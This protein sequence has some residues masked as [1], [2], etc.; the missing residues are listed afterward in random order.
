M[1]KQEYEYN[2]TEIAV[3][4]MSGRFPGAR[5]INEFWENLRNGIESISSFSEQELLEQGNDPQL[6]QKPNY[7]RAKGFVED[8]Q[9]FDATFFDYTP[10]EAT[11]MDPQ[12]R[13]LHE[14][15]WEA[16]EDA[17]YS[18]GA[19]EK[20]IGLFAG[21]AFNHSWM[22]RAFARQTMDNSEILETSMYTL[23]DYLC[24]LV[25]YKLDLKGPSF[26]I[27]TACSTSLVAIHQASQSLLLGECRLAVAGGV[28]ITLPSKTGYLY[29][30]GMINSPDGH[31]RTFDEQA[32]GTVFG[33]GAGIVVLKRLQEAIDAGDHIY[34]VIRGSAIN[35]D[36]NQKVGYTAPS[37]KGQEAVIRAALNVAEVDPESIS[38][39]EAHGTGTALG[40]PIE[41]EALKAAFRT[42]QRGYC[43]I[44]SVKSNI[45]HLNAA[46][47]VAGFLK[48]V[49]ALQHRQIPP[50]L[51]FERANP[52]IDFATSP[53]V[54]STQL[55][56]WHNEHY[57]LRAGVSSFGIGGTNA[58]VILEEAP[59]APVSCSQRDWHVLPLSAKSE[60][61]LTQMAQRLAQAL[62]A[63]PDIAL[64]DVAYTLQ[65]GR[66]HFGH[67]RMVVAHSV[68]QA[69]AQLGQ[70]EVDPGN[71]G[72]VPQE[73][74]PL[75]WLFPGQGT[76]YVN[77]GQHLYARDAV[78]RAAIE[79]CLDLAQAYGA[80]DLRALLYP[81]AVDAESEQ[82]LQET[83]VAQPLLFSVEYAL[84]QV[85]LQW[86]IKP[87][88][89][90]GHSIGEYVAAC[91]AGVFSLEDAMRL[92]VKRGQLMSQAPTGAMLSV[93][94]SEEH[95]Q[96]YLR[97]GLSLA[98]VNTPQMCVVAG[99]VELI[100]VLEAEMQRDGHR[101]R[102]V[103]TSHAFHSA[104]ME[105]VLEA[106]GEEAK[107]VT[108][109]A[110]Q[111][112]Y[113]SNVSGTWIQE[114]EATDPA[115]WVRHLRVHVRFAEGISQMLGASTAM[116]VEVGPGNSLSTFARQGQ[117]ASKEQLVL[118]LLRHRREEQP[119]DAYLLNRLGRLWVAG[120]NLNWT[121]AYAEEQRR[122]LSLPT[123]PF[124]RQRFWLELSG[125]QWSV[126]PHN[127]VATT[128]EHRTAK[129]EAL[130]KQHLQS[131]EIQSPVEADVDG[132]EHVIAQI[133]EQ[134]LGVKPEL[135]DSFFDIGG[136]S[137][138]ATSLT[139]RIQ[140][141]CHVAV[142]I[143]DIFQFA[144]VKALSD[145]IRQLEKTEYAEIVPVGKKEYYA[146]SSSQRRTYIIQRNIGTG[147]TYNYPM[148]MFV[149][150][151]P[152]NKRIEAAFRSLINRHEIFR[153]TFEF[154]DGEP[155]QK[156]HEQID[157]SIEYAHIQE[158][159]L[160][161][162]IKA[163]IQPFDL[164]HVPLLRVMSVQLADQ[165]YALFLD[166][167]NIL[168]DG[169][170]MNIFIKEFCELYRGAIL[171]PL[172][173]QYKDYAEWQQRFLT[174]ALIRKQ[175]AYW[176]NKFATIPTL[177]MP[178]DASRQQTQEFSGETI[179]FTVSS[180]LAEMLHQFARERN[181]TLNVLFYSAFTLLLHKYSGQVDLVVG[182]LV[183]GRRRTEVAN[184][185]GLFTNFLPVRN[186]IVPHSS[187]VQYLEMVNLLLL[188]AYD[189]Q[190]Y[191]FDLIVEKLS[192]RIPRS[193]NPL[194]DAMFVYHNEYDPNITLDVE[195]LQFER[196]DFIK[197][198]AKLDIKLDIIDRRD[199]EHRCVLQYNNQLYVRQ[200]IDDF[201]AHFL[202]LLHLIIEQ[203]ESMLSQFEI[204][205]F[206]EEQAIQAKRALLEQDVS[207]ATAMTLVVCATFT[208]TP[209]ENYIK[210][211]GRTFEQPIAVQFSAYN[212]IFQDLLDPSSLLSLNNGA[213]LLLIRFED[214]LRDTTSDEQTQ[215]R[216][217]EQNFADL[218]RVIQEKPKSIPYFVGLFAL[219][220]EQNLS[221]TLQTYITMLNMRWK[222]AMSALEN[223]YVIDFSNLSDLYLVEK[224]F[225]P[226]TDRTAHL[227]FTDGFYAAMGTEIARKIIAW[228]QHPFKVI[229]LDADN[230][231]WQGVI[232][233][234]GPDGIR[235]DTPYIELQKFMQKKRQEGFLLALCSKNNDVDVWEV[236]SSNAQMLLKKDDFV[237][238]RVNWQPKSQNIK[239][240]AVELRVGLDSFIFIDDSAIECMEVMANCPEVLTLQLPQSAQQIP[241]FLNHLWGLDKLNVTA[242]DQQR[243]AMY[244]AEQRR[245]ETYGAA[246]TH[247]DFL[248]GL[249]LKMSMQV[250]EKKQS[251]RTAQMT[252]RTNQFNVS[253]IRRSEQQIQ[254]L[255]MQT[256]M[257]C[258]FVEV[259]DR[260]GYYG[261]TG[262]V[263]AKQV[264]DTLFIDTF[265]LS[266]RVLGRNIEDAVVDA[267]L[268]Y[269]LE[270]GINQ[271]ATYYYATS[272]NQIVKEFLERTNWLP[273]VEAEDYISYTLDVQKAATKQAHQVD[274]YYNTPLPHRQDAIAVSIES[275]PIQTEMHK[276][277]NV[278][279]TSRSTP[280]LQ[281]H[282]ALVNDQNS[283][284]RAYYA[285]IEHSS[286]VLLLQL[287]VSTVA[288]VDR[289]QLY[290]APRNALEM[291]LCQLWSSVL[292]G[293]EVGI[294]DSFFA[295]GGNSLRAIKLEVELEK[296][297]LI[298][299]G[300][301][302]FINP[303][304]RQYAEKIAGIH[305]QPSVFTAAAD[306]EPAQASANHAFIC[307]IKPFNDFIYK[308]CFYSSVFPI[309]LS[310]KRSIISFIINDSIVYHYDE[311]QPGTGLTIMFQEAVPISS[312]LQSQG[313]V[314]VTQEHVTNIIDTI[315][316]A[317]EQK[318][319][320]VLWVDCFY[321]SIRTD[322]YHRIHH[323]HT[324]LFYGYERDEQTFNIIEHQNLESPVYE[325]R[326]I[327]FQDVENAYEGFIQHFHA[328]QH[329]TYFQFTA[330]PDWVDSASNNLLETFKHNNRVQKALFLDG[331]QALQHF[332]DDYEHMIDDQASLQEYASKL[333]LALSDIINA[334]KVAVYTLEHLSIEQEVIDLLKKIVEGW[335]A[336]R[337]T[338]A[339]FQYSGSYRPKALRASIVHLDKIIECE[340]LYNEW[341][342]K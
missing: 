52:R 37:T 152:D 67:R 138:K 310:L 295:I 183:A 88:G 224:I 145:H 151:T 194:F 15:V 163:F 334:K 215:V 317:L 63:K 195:G 247:A 13:L 99:R 191:P 166:M 141:E 186:L 322:V 291:K 111:I 42:Q 293:V 305:M 26:T 279:P 302:I 196:Y 223:V 34:A 125:L 244:V 157:F 217:L 341:L 25:S 337:I 129:Q 193:R 164:E 180:E 100:E 258:W 27:Q 176:L 182:S 1:S 264:D 336:I 255:L 213:N 140:K 267:L 265:L 190:D 207:E 40:D 273:G 228:K 233:E 70:Q 36:G 29:Q 188:E 300:E 58:H 175:E 205:T 178:L 241:T 225:D 248:Q 128:N 149:Y 146:L 324:L 210:W 181:I 289:T 46:A 204:F 62:Q 23:R 80:G 109:H 326:K 94:L 115:Y 171:A 177:E 303:T 325:E 189:N 256:D 84:A 301:T 290:I 259:E 87:Q 30:E 59:A 271:L 283:R 221:P 251:M 298:I 159:E 232:G 292:E 9:G 201:I 230:T 75:F 197:D 113:L 187:F 127:V 339:K 54:V 74:R 44:G 338:I 68:E 211:W 2:G 285:P 274:I 282:N 342:F 101:C 167:H 3:I 91:L 49:L 19:S 214:W 60:T 236:F 43:Q 172:S 162:S 329:E 120:V 185:I 135:N 219:A 38:Y 270:H 130:P 155:V 153:T 260:F 93:E 245:Q 7:V 216:M 288:V 131:T 266:C 269:C 81:T 17:G 35:N 160:D 218:V 108:L 10:K 119:D 86:G 268:R 61:A 133:W 106:F 257:H 296:N 105:P 41:I 51:H 48:T 6:I 132:I 97:E 284:H 147:T 287:P 50:S 73:S 321:E 272:K 313:I 107:R 4:G 83:Q 57:P 137:L 31:N 297:D 184:L 82:R 246:L 331:I 323:S 340:C 22:L 76:Q 312:V 170:S 158:D 65:A 66:A 275:S 123:Y 24:T 79:R 39:I 308:G 263:F 121:T 220:S 32:G 98:A 21:A 243:T 5:N 226:V 168:A 333:I 55:T 47:G 294:D 20:S 116:L 192:H 156:I 53:F 28:S 144:T 14:C 304:V 134:I 124:E 212:Q 307:G 72:V 299:E 254:E 277:D 85:L 136:D 78:F 280:A 102:R 77:M 169:M 319:P 250:L 89:M 208:A 8:I 104:L 103:P 122:R 114:E 161:A 237:T 318:Q 234:D 142:H 71:R 242:E 306:L 90:L 316:N 238:W 154:I 117:G 253:T 69:I 126:E 229:V 198:T 143:S 332:K 203:P 335:S 148:V 286:E 235:V 16:L 173:I 92:V 18:A 95:V 276:L 239:E 249:H 231:L 96:S 315:I 261:I 118:N 150:G 199:G 179:Q 206:E 202:K 112:P 262:E 64:A 227:P 56:P 11:F 139:S 311:N 165:K 174:S 200:T 110:P 12:F 281:W 309:L 33:D 320:V 278:E 314:Y 327:S 328:K 252:Q 222:Q 330:E 45:G 209:I 240:L